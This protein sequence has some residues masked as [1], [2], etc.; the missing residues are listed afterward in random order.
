M[1]YKI[2][3]I[4]DLITNKDSDR[5]MIDLLENNESRLKLVY[6]KKHEEIEPHISHTNVCLFVTDGEI[7][8]IFNHDDDC[9][10]SACG[11]GL[12]SEKD[13]E[14]KKYKIKK[15]QM[16]LFEKDIVHSVKALKDSS[17]LIIKI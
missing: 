1:L 13:D 15:D 5:E 8:I 14:G 4:D 6:L 17:F 2:L 16:F 11:C 9:T 3:E 7:E 10:C 12:P